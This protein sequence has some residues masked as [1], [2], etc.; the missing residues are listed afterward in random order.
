MLTL[1]F[2]IISYDYY[3]IKQYKSVKNNFNVLSKNGNR[4]LYV[5]V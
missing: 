2:I 3:F 5:T 4:G 1:E